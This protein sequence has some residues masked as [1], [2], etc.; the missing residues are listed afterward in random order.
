MYLTERLPRETGRDY[1]L[2][3]LKDN[4]VRLELKPGSLVSE[5]ELASEL[6]LSRTPVREALIELAKVKIVEIYPQRG[7]AIARIDCHM[8]E[9][10]KFMRRVLECAVIELDCALA[11][12][13]AIKMLEENIRFQQ[14]YLENF[15]VETLTD[16]DNQF[17]RLLFEIAQKSQVYTLMD[18][19]SIHFDRVRSMALNT[20]KNTKIIQ[21]HQDL[22]EVI[23]RKDAVGARALM[24]AHL[25]RYQ[26]NVDKLREDY[27][28]YFI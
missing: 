5:N 19:I 20:V 7:S 16:L 26:I 22:M 13:Q 2:R 17:H 14:F 8:V 28:D 10:A 27:P 1:A 9:E 24:E 18:T 15:Y 12:G 4:I 11:D 23:A 3:M 25:G 21:D 6:G